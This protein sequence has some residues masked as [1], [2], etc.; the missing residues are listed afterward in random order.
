MT[1]Y[2]KSDAHKVRSI[3]CCWF[4]TQAVALLLSVLTPGGELRRRLNP[5]RVRERA[6][7][8]FFF[9]I[10]CLSCIF[11]WSVT[12]ALHYH[13]YSSRFDDKAEVNKKVS[14]SEMLDRVIL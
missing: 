4:A 2:K 13:K 6:S 11:L 1:L 14:V 8:L 3:G 12:N 5:L 10:H 9:Y 7:V